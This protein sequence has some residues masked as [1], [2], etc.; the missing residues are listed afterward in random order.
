[1]DTEAEHKSTARPVIRKKALLAT[2]IIFIVLSSIAVGFL[3]WKNNPSR[4]L[5]PSTVANQ[6]ADFTP[7][8][9]FDEI[10]GGYTLDEKSVSFD[11]NIVIMTLTKPGAPSIVLTEQA[12]PEDL[13]Q[14]LLAGEGTQKIENTVAPAL[15]NNVE[16]RLVGIMTS[17]QH[18]ILL[19]INASGST[20]SEDV[21]TML[22]AL[23]PHKRD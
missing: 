5:L 12:L 6:I 20:K 8:F 4:S 15:I 1:M 18:N 3:F 10:P 23:R 9:F 2:V 7:Y 16:G 21:T 13:P 19:L 14:D 17:E 11:Q 22:Q